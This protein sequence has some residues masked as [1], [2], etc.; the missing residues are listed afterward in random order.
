MVVVQPSRHADRQT[1]ARLSKGCRYRC[2]SNETAAVN[3]QCCNVERP[4]VMSLGVALVGLAV[5]FACQLFHSALPRATFPR[6]P[7]LHPE[8]FPGLALSAYQ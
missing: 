7:G 5:F 6:A 1:L 3:M 8:F 4:A 2:R